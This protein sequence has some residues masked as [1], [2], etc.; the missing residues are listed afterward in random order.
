MRSAHSNQSLVL[1][2]QVAQPLVPIAPIAPTTMGLV[3]LGGAVG[4]TFIV[5]GS[6]IALLKTCFKICQPNEILIISGRKYRQDSGKEVG[7]ST[8]HLVAQTDEERSFHPG[9]PV[10][11]VGRSENRLWVVS[12]DH[13]IG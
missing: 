11:V 2:A 4:V 3:G 5:L 12:V 13:A 10:L 8:L 9:D 6:A 7:G 1:Q